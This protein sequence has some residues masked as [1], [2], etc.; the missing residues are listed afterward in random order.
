MAEIERMPA[1]PEGYYWRVRL[2][3]SR[4]SLVRRRRFGW[5][6]AVDSGWTGANLE[7]TAHQVRLT[8]HLLA[9]KLYFRLGR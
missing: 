8:A 1:L 4:V 7:V 3:H 6:K 5:D 9:S 2:K